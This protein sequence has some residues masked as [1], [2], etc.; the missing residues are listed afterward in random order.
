MVV[1]DGAQIRVGVADLA[2]TDD[3]AKLV[4]SGLGSCVAVAIHDQGGR[5]G[6]L[7]AML[8]EAPSDVEDPP[9]YVDTGIVALRNELD[10]I[11]ADTESLVGKV[12]GGSTMLNLGNGDPIGEKN[13]AATERALRRAGIEL[14]GSE[15]GGNAGRSV[16]F[17]PV[18]GRMEITR[19]DD[20]P[21]E[22]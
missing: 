17:H 21:T 19:V 13:V 14:R 1:A 9:K 3:H 18:D 20:R 15:T 6:L 12:A 10:G 5:G 7:H 8:P 2:V 22:L 16:T 11:G 4:T